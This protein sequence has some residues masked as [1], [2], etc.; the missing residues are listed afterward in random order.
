ML[1][2]RRAGKNGDICCL[3][4]KFRGLNGGLEAA[5]GWS[6]GAKPPQLGAGIWWV[7]APPTQG[8]GDEY[9][10]LSINTLKGGQF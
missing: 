6:R 5:I 1:R 10:I 2:V 3:S 7:P 8:K 4:G 9:L